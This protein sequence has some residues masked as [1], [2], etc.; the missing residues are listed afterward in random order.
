KEGEIVGCGTRFDRHD[1]VIDAAPAIAAP[2]P[3]QRL[4]DLVKGRELE[5]E[6][7]IGVQAERRAVEYELVLAADLVDMDQRHAALGHAGDGKVEAH[8]V[9]VARIG[10][11]VGH[12][13]QLGA[14]LG[15]AFNH[16]LVVAPFGPDIFADRNAD[17]HAAE[18]D[19]TGRR[20]RREDASFVEHAII[21][22][23]HLPT[24][25]SDGAAVEQAIRVVELAL[26]EPRRAD[27]Q[28]RTAARSFARKLFDL[29][30][31]GRLER[32]LE[33][34]ILRRI[35]GE[36]K[37]RKRHDV[38]AAAGSLGARAARR[39]GVAGDVPDDRIELSDRD[40]QTVGGPRI[41]DLGL[42]RRARAPQSPPSAAQISPNRSASANSQAMPAMSSARPTAAEPMSLTRPIW[43]SIA[44]L[45]RSASFSTAVFNSSTTS[46]KA[47][48][49][50]SAR[51]FQASSAIRKA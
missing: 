43:G 24:H 46:T 49:A 39:V 51:R 41:H 29:R 21:R 1:E 13:H 7:A 34:E 28:G 35:A 20:P 47:T 27:Q 36:E 45:T 30:S 10:R 42:A 5:G 37:F 50:M 19:R 26:L 14:G 8:V 31:A 25:G 38:G 22:Q 15:K 12:D 17:A 3:A 16:V 44:R 6:R 2:L 18:I 9:L 32:R 4:D 23:V 11:A 33:H 40:G 48:T